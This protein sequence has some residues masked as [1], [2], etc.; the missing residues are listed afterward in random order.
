MIEI[1]WTI[2]CAIALLAVVGLFCYCIIEM[3]RSL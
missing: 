2:T 1:I 3:M